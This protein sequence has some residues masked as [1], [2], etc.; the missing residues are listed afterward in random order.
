MSLTVS[1]PTVTFSAKF[2][3]QPIHPTKVLWGL[4]FMLAFGLTIFYWAGAPF[5][6]GHRVA[7]FELQS[8]SALQL[9]GITF[10][11]SGPRQ[12]MVGPVALDPSMN[13]L[14]LVLH[15][16]HHLVSAPDRLSC[17]IAVRDMAGLVVWQDSRVLSSG[18]VGRSAAMSGATTTLT[19]LFGTLAVPKASHY[20]FEVRFLSQYSDVVRSADLEIRRNVSGASPVVLGTGAAIALLCLVGLTLS[21]NGRDEEV[22]L[23]NA[24]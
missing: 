20:T 19:A 1:R 12:E 9:P 10:T 17:E 6:T 4:G 11:K 24:A 2:N 16:R 15:V 13:N 3:G 14:G 22:Q 21:Q 18:R 7:A 8:A 23:P 5:F